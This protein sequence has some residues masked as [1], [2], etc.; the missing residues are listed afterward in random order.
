MDQDGLIRVGGRLQNSS[1]SYDQ[2]HP[3]ILPRKHL[4]TKLI[5]GEEH[6]RLMHCGPTMLLS[7]ITEH[8]WPIAGRTLAKEIVRKCVTC[9]RVRPRTTDYLMGN[10]PKPRVEPCFPFFN[11]GC[12]YAGPFLLKEKAAK[13]SRLNKGY[14]CL[15]ICLATKAIHIETISDL[16][17]DCFLATLRR[18]IGRRGKPANIFSDNGKSFIGANAELETSTINSCLI[19]HCTAPFS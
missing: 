5:M 16:T 2:K 8:Y 18:F 3:I 10:L 13:N 15:F 14:I 17:T 12:D 6:G 19:R 1:N 11:T 9:F 4:I 7:A